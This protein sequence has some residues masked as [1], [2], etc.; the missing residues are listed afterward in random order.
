ME[1]I[2]RLQFEIRRWSDS[3]FGEG[4]SPVPV[5]NHLA[6]EVKELIEAIES[7]KNFYKTA[8]SELI[9]D[10]R[11]GHWKLTETASKQAREL[12]HNVIEEMADC[13]IILMEAYALYPIT[14]P[15]VIKA[16]K[17][18]MEINKKRKWGKPDENGVIEH[19]EE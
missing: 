16:V 17:A 4:R 11:D 9:G 15:A 7:E 2:S 1:E 5:L 12:Q 6:K 13:F 14:M 10:G 8:D 18:K 19:I 3:A